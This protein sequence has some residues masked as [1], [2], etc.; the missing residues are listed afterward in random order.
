MGKKNLPVFRS[1]FDK[2]DP[3]A[4]PSKKAKKKS[5]LDGARARLG[6]TARGE[7]APARAVAPGQIVSFESPPGSGTREDAVVVFA[8]ASEVHALVDGTRLRRLSVEAV[9]V[10]SRVPDSLATLAADAR[11]FGALIEGQAVRYADDDKGLRDAKLVEKCRYGALVARD[12]GTIVAVG[13]RKL[14]PATSSGAA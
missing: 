3:E 11:A 6:G 4:D 5:T 9:H 1:V 14:W 8:N 7:E 10:E 13:F 12:D 2:E